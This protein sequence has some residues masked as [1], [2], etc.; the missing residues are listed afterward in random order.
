VS[1]TKNIL[2][3]PQAPVLRAFALSNTLLALDYDGTLAPIASTPALVRM[4]GRTSR[5]IVEVA[6]YY[7]SIVITGRP[8]DEVAERLSAI[9]LRAV[10]GNYGGEPSADGPPARVRRWA[11]VLAE[12]LSRHQGV[13]VE[14]KRFSVTVH[15]RHARSKRRTLADICDAT[16][17]LRG[18]RVLG[19]AQ[20]V[21]IL[22]DTGPDKG[23]ALQ[24]ARRRLGCETA[25][26]VGDDDTDEDAFASAPPDRLLSIRV[27]SSRTSAARYRLERQTDIDALLRR[28]LRLRRG[29]GQLSAISRHRDG[30]SWPKADR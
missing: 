2:A 26:Y 25:I 23:V 4:R 27:G 10:F 8:L 13:L 29:S 30:S 20:T 28:L 18:A 19:G 24:L 5:L 14:D 3:A 21:T 16:R 6:R 22:P 11:G 7:P 15:Y 9:P 12:L 1:R 17:R